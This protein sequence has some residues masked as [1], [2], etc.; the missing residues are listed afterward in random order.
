MLIGAVLAP[1]KRT[2]SQVLRVM[3]LAQEQQYQKYDRVLNG[4]VWSSRQA[5]Y[6]FKFWYRPLSRLEWWCWA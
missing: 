1:G 4:A 2:V 3:G 5:R 6:S